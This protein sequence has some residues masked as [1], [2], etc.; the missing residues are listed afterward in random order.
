MQQH[1]W[2]DTPS[3]GWVTLIQEFLILTGD[4]FISNITSTVVNR[5]YFSFSLLGLPRKQLNLTMW[6]FPKVNHLKMVI[7]ENFLRLT[8][9]VRFLKNEYFKNV[10]FLILSILIL[11]SYPYPI[12]SYFSFL[13]HSAWYNYLVVIKQIYFSKSDVHISDNIAGVE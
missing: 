3:I 13:F 12:L 10:N 1:V 6:N 5:K 4:I 8:G 2:T 9:T 7:E 11:F